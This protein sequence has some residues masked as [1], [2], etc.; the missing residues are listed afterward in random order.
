MH[1]T[2]VGRSWN[3][4]RGEGLVFD[5]HA[6]AGRSAGGSSPL[7][8]E[9]AEM[10]GDVHDFANKEETGDFAGSLVLLKSSSVS[11]PPAV[12]SAFS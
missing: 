2:R 10:A 11:T 3:G 5:L 9:A 1:C 7:E 6:A 8:V 4:N 12:T